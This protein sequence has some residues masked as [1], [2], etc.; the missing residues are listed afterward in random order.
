MS[1]PDEQRP[2][3]QPNPWHVQPPSPQPEQQR[4]VPDQHLGQPQWQPQWQSSPPATKQ[5]NVLAIIALV[6]A[7]LALVMVLGVIVLGGFLSS[8]AGIN[9]SSS[10][11][12]QGTAPQVVVGDPYLG[13][14]LA[15]EVSRVI[16]GDGGDVR[17]MTCP[18]TP[19]VD[20]GAVAVCHGVVDGSDSTITVTFE[21][22]LGH[23]TLVES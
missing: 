6:V 1:N 3:A 13:S 7:C 2:F 19:A 11:D 16:R 5:S 9:G 22:G 4:H 15:D 14:L 18:E 12:L 23:F 21:D 10:G 20:T 8:V 17:S